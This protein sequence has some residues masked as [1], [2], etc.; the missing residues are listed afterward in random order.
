[1]PSLALVV[2]RAENQLAVLGIKA[3]FALPL[4]FAEV[5]VVT[6]DLIQDQLAVDQRLRSH[7]V[8]CMRSRRACQC[9]TAQPQRGRPDA[10]L[11]NGIQFHDHPPVNLTVFYCSFR[12]LACYFVC[13]LKNLNTSGI[14]PAMIVP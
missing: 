5:V 7:L 6:R 9:G 1:M 3:L 14:A 10:R 4:R 8:F 12:N 2:P 13:L 11:T